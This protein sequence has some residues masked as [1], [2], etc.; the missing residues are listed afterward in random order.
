MRAKMISFLQLA[1]EKKTSFWQASH[2]IF[3]TSNLDRALFKFITSLI[4]HVKHE[5]THR[6]QPMFSCLHPIRLGYW[7]LRN[8]GYKQK[9]FYCSTDFLFFSFYKLLILDQ[10]W[11]DFTFY[12]K[13]ADAQHWK[14]KSC[15]DH[16]KI[17][18]VIEWL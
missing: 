16:H 6:E 1:A 10:H 3:G 17:Y 13:T 5:K 12:W 9:T 11:H 18:L 2:T 4:L 14:V 7:S 15:Y 8:F